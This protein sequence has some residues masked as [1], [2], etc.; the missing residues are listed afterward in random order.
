MSCQILRGD[1]RKVIPDVKADLIFTSPPYN[2]GSKARRQDGRRSAGGFD[3]KSYG[4]IRD[5][6]DNLPEEEYQRQ[7]VEFLNWSATRLKQDGVL[8]YNHKP[9]R[10]DGKMIHPMEWITK[11]T[12]LILMEEIV[13]DRGSTHNHCNKLMWPR[14][15]RLY[16]LRRNGGKYPLRNTEDLD[17]RSDVWNIQRSK[18]NGHNAPF[19]ETLARAVINA[20]SSKGD[21]VMDPYVGSGTT[22][23]M[24]VELKREFIGSEVMSKYYKQALAR[25]KGVE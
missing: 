2:I 18:A 20:W 13:W 7:Q 11:V 14:T 19:P 17:F 1:Y 9:R 24:C 23:A 10:K 4:A 25:V 6:P 8:V 21:L 15:E 16:V 5:Y 22:P 3:P 12:D